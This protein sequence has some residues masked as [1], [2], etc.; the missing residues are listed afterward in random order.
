MAHVDWTPELVEK[1]RELWLAG[2]SPIEMSRQLGVS[3][4]A[5]IGKAHRIDL[6]MRPNAIIRAS[7]Q[8]KARNAEILKLLARGLCQKDVADVLRI[9][10][11]VVHNVRKR[12]LAGGWDPDEHREPQES[13]LPPLASL[14]P[15]QPAPPI[16]AA[17]HNISRAKL[18]AFKASIQ[19]R[20]LECWPRDRLQMMWEL[21]SRGTMPVVMAELLTK[22]FPDLPALTG[23]EISDFINLRKIPRGTPVPDP[24]VRPDCWL[25]RDLPE[26]I[27]DDE[28]AEKP[29]PE[30]APFEINTLP[31]CEIRDW[32][33]RARLRQTDDQS[34]KDFLRVVNGERL[35]HGLPVFRPAREDKRWMPGW[36]H[37]ASIDGWASKRRAGDAE[38]P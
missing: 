23:Y 3:K 25:Y 6:P 22:Q 15:V 37:W 11:G 33:K 10:K 13:T 35:R 5:L 2:V 12:A 24:M 17:V 16:R 26:I 27:D 21:H 1:L 30:R 20:T 31:W 18:R 32:A 14:E 38:A 4:D 7:P 28:P 29:A 36:K 9:S 8:A 19:Q 34:D